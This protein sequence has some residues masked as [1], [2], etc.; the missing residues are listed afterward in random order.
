MG[1]LSIKFLLYAHNQVTLALL[2]CEMQATKMEEL[3]K[4]KSSAILINI[5]TK[6]GKLERDIERRVNAGNKVNRILHTVAALHHSWTSATSERCGLKEDVVSR[7]ENG[8]LRWSDALL[9]I[10]SK[11]VHFSERRLQ[12]GTRIIISTTRTKPW[13]KTS[14]HTKREMPVLDIDGI[15][16]GRSNYYR[17]QVAIIEAS[18]RAAG[19]ARE[20]YGASLCRLPTV[21]ETKAELMMAMM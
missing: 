20:I 19:G 18:T 8:M 9:N 1:E 12:M 4:C 5:F 16:L 21:S 15:N 7:V 11:H 6:E 2:A 10:V 13:S 3:N 14:P 17:K